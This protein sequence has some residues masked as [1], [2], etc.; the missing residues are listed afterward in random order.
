MN[1]YDF[2]LV[3]FEV[4]LGFVN[5]AGG[6]GVAAC[7]THAAPSSHC[8]CLHNSIVTA[9]PKGVAPMTLV[10]R[11]GHVVRSTRGH[12]KGVRRAK[13]TYDASEAGP[14]LCDV[15]LSIGPV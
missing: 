8:L 15:L 13:H 14:V 2:S 5:L 7:R 10:V 1:V 6:G 11:R 12:V 3:D 4:D 9:E